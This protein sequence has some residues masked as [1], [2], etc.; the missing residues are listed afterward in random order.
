M[1]KSAFT[2]HLMVRTRY[3]LLSLMRSVVCSDA[4]RHEILTRAAKVF[5]FCL[6]DDATASHAGD[7]HIFTGDGGILKLDIVH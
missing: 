1:V 3:I 6:P 4:V 5:Y 2:S 7:E